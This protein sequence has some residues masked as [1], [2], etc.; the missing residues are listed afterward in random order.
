MQR[1]KA[2]FDNAGW[3]AAYETLAANNLYRQ[4]MVAF[5]RNGNQV[6]WALMIEPGLP[7]WS[8]LAF[9]GLLGAKTALIACVGVDSKARKRG[10]GHA[11][12]IHAIRDLRSRG[13]KH[14]LVDWVVLTDWYEKLGF[15]TWRSYTQYR[16]GA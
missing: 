6:G 7:V 15:R 11:L 2:N 4:V 14:I 16:L 5:E 9:I 8:D 12:I 10:I 13:M 3:I 1:Q